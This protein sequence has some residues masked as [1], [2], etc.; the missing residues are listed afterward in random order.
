MVMKPLSWVTDV[1]LGGGAV[2][3]SPAPPLP[4]GDGGGGGGGADSEVPPLQ[5]G[6][7]ISS[8]SHSSGHRWLL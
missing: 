4:P 1:H 3:V 6:M 2:V 7:D 8:V 5:C